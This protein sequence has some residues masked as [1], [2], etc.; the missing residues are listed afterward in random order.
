M[1]KKGGSDSQKLSSGRYHYGDRGNEV[2]QLRH[3]FWLMTA[4][5]PEAD[6]ESKEGIGNAIQRFERVHC[7]ARTRG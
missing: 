1:V 5:C 4:G 7:Q 2:Y 3:M 6:A